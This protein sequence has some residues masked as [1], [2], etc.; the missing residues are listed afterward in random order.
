MPSSTIRQNPWLISG[1][2]L[3]VAAAV[4]PFTVHTSDFLHYGVPWARA[5]NGWQPWGIY[6]AD[7]NYPPLFS[8]FLTAAEAVR[9]LTGSAEAGR[10]FLV[11]IKVPNVVALVLG[12]LL[13]WKG[14][15]PILGET[16]ARTAAVLYIAS[17]TLF[18]NAAMWAQCEALL[19]FFLVAALIATLQN[20]PELGGAFVGAA[21][22]T[23]PQAMVAVPVL[24]VY[25]LRTFPVRRAL[26]AAA[27]A[28]AVVVATAAPHVLA[29]EGT[30]VVRSYTAAIDQWPNRTLG[31]FNHWYLLDGFDEYVRHMPREVA[32][33]DGRIAFAG[34]TFKALGLTALAAYV[35][36]LVALAWRLPTGA[37]LVFGEV[38]SG[39]AFFMLAT[40]MH[41][42]YLVPAAAIA[43]LLAVTSPAG[44]ALYGWLAFSAT[45]NQLIVMYRSR[46]VLPLPGPTLDNA[47]LLAS[48]LIAIGNV[49]AFVWATV[50]IVRERDCNAT[51]R[52]AEHRTPLATQ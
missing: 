24:A 18:V 4:A 22:A 20:R 49:C 27:L 8:Y 21:L 47:L 51:P 45:L 41:E 39:F 23:K 14:L 17:P 34:L 28:V 37:T 26:S 11:M 2:V 15:A 48:A 7:A 9:R 52:A 16:R 46:M 5:T 12:G 25:I 44:P 3:V 40:Q 36:F 32:R 19:A 30:G 43:S 42:R 38:M 6:R 13:S 31:A 29:G 35:A 50:E 1:V 10:L 33:D